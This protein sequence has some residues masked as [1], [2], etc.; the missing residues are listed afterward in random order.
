MLFPKS[1]IFTDSSVNMYVITTFITHD[2]IDSQLNDYS[3]CSILSLFVF[4]L[5][6]SFKI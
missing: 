2:S 1:L 6:F 3:N 4:I 5:N